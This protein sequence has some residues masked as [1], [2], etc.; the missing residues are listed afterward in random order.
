[1]HSK[2]EKTV[3]ISKNFQDV[4]SV[5]DF[6][7]GIIGDVR[8]E[9]NTDLLISVCYFFD[10]PKGF[11]NKDIIIRFK[12]CFSA[13]EICLCIITSKFP[14]RH[15]KRNIHTAAERLST[16]PSVAGIPVQSSITFETSSNVTIAETSIVL[17]EENNPE[18]VSNILLSE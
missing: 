12:K 4:N 7:E 17:T 11:Q 13:T 5:F 9:N 6:Y 2:W 18:F 3:I 16:L 14:K 1:M 15:L 10:E 8:W